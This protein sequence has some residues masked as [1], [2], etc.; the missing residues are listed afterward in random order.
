M[1]SGFGDISVYMLIMGFPVFIIS[2]HLKEQ[3]YKTLTSQLT[4]AGNN[5][6]SNPFLTIKAEAGQLFG[7]RPK[8]IIPAVN[9][10]TVKG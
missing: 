1:V 9:A 4:Q 10:G 7:G 5:S 2:K 6:G 3:I 8:K